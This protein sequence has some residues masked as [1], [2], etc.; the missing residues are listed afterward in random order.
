[1]SP[2]GGE[3]PKQIPCRLDLAKE[4]PYTVLNIVI[5]QSDFLLMA[6]EDWSE[7]QVLINRPRDGTQIR[8]LTLLSMPP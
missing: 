5:S 8:I 2:Y 7:W 6:R 3:G 4:S 1:M